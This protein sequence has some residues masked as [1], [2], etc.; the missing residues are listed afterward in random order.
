[1]PAFAG[2]DDKLTVLLLVAVG[3]RLRGDDEKPER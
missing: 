3:P 2:T 1:M